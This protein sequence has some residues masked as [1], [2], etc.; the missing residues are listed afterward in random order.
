MMAAILT[1]LYP[2]SRKLNTSSFQGIQH[3]IENNKAVKSHT[4]LRARGQP[5]NI[6]NNVVT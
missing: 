6:S 5:K 2:P 4:A 3:L 1:F